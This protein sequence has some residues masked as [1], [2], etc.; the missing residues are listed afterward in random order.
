ME[1][2]TREAEWEKQESP[3]K[4]GV[5]KGHG[6]GES[7]KNSDG[8]EEVLVTQILPSIRAETMKLLSRAPEVDWSLVG[9]I[10]T[11]LNIG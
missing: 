4:G 8:E 11:L 6:L 2:N 10:F 5:A 9:L 1:G 3:T 7:S